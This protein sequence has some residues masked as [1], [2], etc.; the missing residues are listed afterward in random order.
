GVVPAAG[1]VPPGAAGV[2]PAAAGVAPAAGTG[3]GGAGGGSAAGG[4]EG[5]AAPAAEGRAPPPRARKLRGPVGVA[6]VRRLDHLAGAR[7]LEEH[8]VADVHAHVV[9]VAAPNPEEDE[10]ALLEVVEA[11][12]GADR[13]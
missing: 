1:T 5:W 4:V 6:Q 10:V 11:D 7:R 3:V 13:H 8:V 9:D 12:R 2:A